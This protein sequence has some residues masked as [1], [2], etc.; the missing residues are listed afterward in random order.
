MRAEDIELLK[1][2]EEARYKSGKIKG[3]L[4]KVMKEGVRKSKKI[5]NM[6]L[7][8]LDKEGMLNEI[9]TLRAELRSARLEI[10][11]LKRMVVYKDETLEDLNRKMEKRK[12]KGKISAIWR[13]KRK[14]SGR[15]T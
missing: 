1:T 6:L 3:D 14:G 4:S 9:D 15:K 11:R 10:E 8:R 2:I 5:M 12:V 13:Y 7:A